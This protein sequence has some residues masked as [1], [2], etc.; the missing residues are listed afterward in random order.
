MW[1]ERTRYL[2]GRGGSRRLL[3]QLEHGDSILYAVQCVNFTDSSRTMD[4]DEV[5]KV[6]TRWKSK[7]FNMGIRGF[8]ISERTFYRNQAKKDELENAA[9][10]TKDIRQFFMK[11]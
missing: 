7:G 6:E 3:L 1:L 8:G 2:V 4:K 5:K 11:Y 9:K 10:C